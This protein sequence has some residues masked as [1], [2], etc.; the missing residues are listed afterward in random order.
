MRSLFGLGTTR[1]LQCLRGRVLAFIWVI[2]AVL[3]RTLL[4]REPHLAI[5]G[6]GDYCEQSSPSTPP[7]MPFLEFTPLNPLR[8]GHGCIMICTA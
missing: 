2:R 8:G 6:S 7:A 4:P 5:G 1:G 3:W